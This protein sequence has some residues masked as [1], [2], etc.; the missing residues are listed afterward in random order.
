MKN[1]LKN[2]KSIPIFLLLKGKEDIGKDFYCTEKL[3]PESLQKCM[4]RGT[5]I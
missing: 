4:F 3:A 5:D 1:K 2:V